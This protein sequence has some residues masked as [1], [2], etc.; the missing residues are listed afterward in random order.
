MN[1]LKPKR[2]LSGVVSYLERFI[3]QNILCLPIRS[4]CII[5]TATFIKS[6]SHISSSLIERNVN[7]LKDVCSSVD[8]RSFGIVDSDLL[9]CF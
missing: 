1:M 3:I 7:C 5:D 4:Q 8:H 6:F 9:N 2:K